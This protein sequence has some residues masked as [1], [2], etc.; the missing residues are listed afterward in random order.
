MGQSQT[1]SRYVVT[2]RRWS[3]QRTCKKLFD[4]GQNQGEAAK[5]P[6]RCLKAAFEKVWLAACE[7]DAGENNI[8][9][10]R[11]TKLD[12]MEAKSKQSAEQ[13]AAVIKTKKNIGNMAKALE[14]K[15]A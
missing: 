7:T 4:S 9:R 13:L 5:L 6:R 3:V 14:R 10:T 8:C 1:I 15:Q 12:E 2:E 11:P